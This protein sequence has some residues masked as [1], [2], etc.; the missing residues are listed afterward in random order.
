MLIVSDY[1][2]HRIEVN[3]ERAGG[4][5]NAVVRIRRILTDEKP[6]VET[7]TCR[8]P[9]AEAAEQ[10]ACVYARRWVDRVVAADTPKQ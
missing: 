8:K 6:H 7:I 5:W 1:R 2:R 10:V 3:A 9:N 4:I